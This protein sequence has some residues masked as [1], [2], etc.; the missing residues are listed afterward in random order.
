MNKLGIGS[1]Q[2]TDSLPAVVDERLDGFGGLKFLRSLL[3]FF[4]VV[5]FGES[6]SAFL[7]CQAL[8]SNVLPLVSLSS[9][10]LTNL[11]L[12]FQ[13]SHKGVTRFLNCSFLGRLTS[14]HWCRLPL[15]GHHSSLLRESGLGLALDKSLHCN[16]LPRGLGL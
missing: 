11:P 4:F 9:L 10:D 6:D 14:F 13:R 8:L 2:L 16:G 7:L 1:F 3:L 15:R 5:S 12:F